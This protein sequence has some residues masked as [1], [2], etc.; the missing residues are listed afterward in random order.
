[1]DSKIPEG[2]LF[3]KQ[4]EWAREEGGFLTVGISDYAQ[5]ALGDIVYV[6]LKAPGTKRG[7]R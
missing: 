3:T 7:S 2:Y 6:D 5:N 4:H 1:M